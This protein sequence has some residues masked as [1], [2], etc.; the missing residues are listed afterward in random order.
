M[1]NESII[2]MDP[3]MLFSLVNMKLRD[4]YSSLDDMCED[5]DL[6]KQNLENKLASE[7]YIYLKEENKFILK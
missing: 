7:G 5:L 3:N 4:F 6:N 2:N 1:D